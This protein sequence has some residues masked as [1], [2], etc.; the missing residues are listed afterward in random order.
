MKHKLK[1]VFENAVWWSGVIMVGLVLGVSLQVVK[2]WTEPTEAPPGGNVGAPVN[3]SLLDQ[4]KAGGLRVLSLF[5][6]GLQLPDGATPGA[7][8]T[9]KADPLNPLISTGEVAWAAGGG[10]GCYVSN[11]TIPNYSGV[12]NCSGDACCLSNF[13]NKGSVGKWGFCHSCGNYSSYQYLKPPGMNC[14][15]GWCYDGDVGESFVCCQN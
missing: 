7:V 6:H 14:S 11:A 5:T 12:A 9:A 2:A 3:T 13:K 1:K 8:L 4:T 15:K 10:G